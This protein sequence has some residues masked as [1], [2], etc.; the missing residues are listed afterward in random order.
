MVKW[1][2][3]GRK[4]P[5]GRG[6]RFGINVP[7]GRHVIGKMFGYSAPEKVAAAVLRTGA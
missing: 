7:L 3:S 1:C 5:G 4:L 6:A 2:L